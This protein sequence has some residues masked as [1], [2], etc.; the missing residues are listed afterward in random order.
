MILFLYTGVSKLL[1][2]DVFKEQ[3]AESA[4]LRPMAPLIAWL[5]PL[6]EFSLSILLF[7]PRLR[8]RLFYASFVLMLLFTGYIIYILNFNKEL[9]CSC[10]GV[11]AELSWKQHLVFNGIFIALAITAILL[12]KGMRKSSIN[13]KAI[14]LVS[15]PL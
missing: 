8:L 5:L 13:K 1:E 14:G 10:G 15:Q 12:E 3:I 2:Y 9:P 11:L 4:I 6:T 7:L